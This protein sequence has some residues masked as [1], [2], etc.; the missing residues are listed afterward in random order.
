MIIGID[1]REGTRLQRAGKGEYVYRLT[2]KLIQNTKH[3]FVLFSDSD[4]PKTWAGPNTKFIVKKLPP[5]M[6]QLWMVWQLN[7]NPRVDV[8]FSPTSLIVPALVFK[9]PVVMAV[10]DF[11][12]FVLPQTH[13]TKARI[14]E[15]IWMNRALQNSRHIISISDSTKKDATKLFEV[16][17]SKITTIHLAASLP[18]EVTDL[19]WN[20]SRPI[21]LHVGTLEPRKNLKRLVEAFGVVKKSQSSASLVL[22]GRWGWQSDQLKQAIKESEY[23]NDIHVLTNLDNTYTKSIYGEADLFVFPSLYEGFGLPPLE[24]MTLGVPV[25]ASNSSSIPEVVGDA[26]VLV[27]P[28]SVPDM[29][30]KINLVLSDNNLQTN[31]KNKGLEQARQFSW[32]RTAEKTLSILENV[33]T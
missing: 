28:K 6:W 22:V 21:I 1:V 20:Y 19:K 27:K 5:M 23:T 4:I 30:D 18:K 11:V 33:S 9:I 26:A 15:K 32:G 24:A 25:V 13:N 31:L 3:E 16:L 17:E 29:A 8:Y 14:L 2:E 10:M 12:S 7:T